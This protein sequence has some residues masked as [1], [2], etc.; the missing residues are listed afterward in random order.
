M[1]LIAVITCLIS[2][3][4]TGSVEGTAPNIVFMLID[5]LGWFD[6]AYHGAAI[7]T[8]NID[9]LSREGIILENYYVQPICTPTR[10]AL[11]TGR[12]PIHTGK[13]SC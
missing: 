12:Y 4:T 8:D 2:L 7:N 9:N 5:D 6:V 10:S 1:F 11:M 3:I 13:K